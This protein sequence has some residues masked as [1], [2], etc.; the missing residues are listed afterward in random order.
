MYPLLMAGI[1]STVWEVSNV[2]HPPAHNLHASTNVKKLNSAP[3]QEDVGQLGVLEVQTFEGRGT[4]A[5]EQII[6]EDLSLL[7]PISCDIFT[8]TIQDLLWMS[9]NWLQE[10]EPTLEVAN[11]PE[12]K[13]FMQLTSKL[14]NMEKTPVTFLPFINSPPNEY[15]TIRTALQFASNKSQ[16]VGAT[17]VFVTFDQP[18]YLKAREITFG[19]TIV[20]LGGFHL[21]MS[22]LGCIGHTMAGSGLKDTM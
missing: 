9:G 13:G 21:L 3:L 7:K 11:I 5:L 12:W 17:I 22:F 6:I 1:R 8:P 20:R 15:S 18:L 19:T 14:T 16:E 2:L 4:N 10:V